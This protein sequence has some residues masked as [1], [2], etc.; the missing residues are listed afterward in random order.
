MYLGFFFFPFGLSL[1]NV[2]FFLQVCLLVLYV[3]YDFSACLLPIV[4]FNLNPSS[5]YLSFA[6][7]S[8]SLFSL[9]TPPHGQYAELD[10]VSRFLDGVCV[11]YHFADLCT[12]LLL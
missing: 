9:S 5:W 2:A 4:H 6:F 12:V 3:L 8:L 7:C 1:L 11:M 10:V